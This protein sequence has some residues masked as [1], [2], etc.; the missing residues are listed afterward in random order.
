MKQLKTI[1][2]LALA[3][4]TCAEGAMAAP[5]PKAELKPSD[6]HAANA[7]ENL[8]WVPP[9][10]L[11][12]AVVEQLGRLAPQVKPVPN[13]KSFG[14]ANGE[15]KVVVA[16]GMTPD[17][18]YTYHRLLSNL[19]IDLLVFKG[20]EPPQKVV[21]ELASRLKVSYR[22][23]EA[24]KGLAYIFPDQGPKRDGV[25][26]TINAATTPPRSVVP[27]VPAATAAKGVPAGAAAP[28]PSPTQAA[29]R[30][31]PQQPAPAA[32]ADRRS[33]DNLWEL[34][35]LAKASDP[36]LGRSQ[37]RYQGSAADLD[38]VRAGLFPRV[39]TSFGLNYVDQ[40]Y[41]NVPPPA[42]PTQNLT[43]FGY[44]YS[45]NASVPLLHFPTHYNIA[46][47]K[48]GVRGE[49]A[50]LTAAKQNLI[51]KLVDAYFGLLKAR[52]D[53]QIA[54][55]EIDRVRQ[56]LEQAQA[57]LKA[58]TGD[59]ISVYEA[60]A[61]LDSVIADLSRA[62]SALRLA[63]QKLSSIVGKPVA[64][65]PDYLP[66]QPGNPEPDDIEWWLTTMEERDPLI[67]QAREG[68]AGTELQT[69]AARAEY[70]PTI[71]AVAAYRISKGNQYPAQIE[72]HT[73]QA[74]AAISVP[75]YSG[76]ETKARIQRATANESER[77]YNL[78]QVREQRRENTKLTF[79]N[80]RYNLNIIR[81]LE[82][83]E[84]SAKIQL[85]AVR[86]GRSIGTR[87][88]IDLL[89]AEHDYSVAQR[90]LQNALYDNVVRMVQLKAAA[91]ILGEND[92]VVA[93]G[94]GK[95]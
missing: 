68:L 87:T 56:A 72:T 53:E 43:L 47:A 86:K 32:T 66:R 69:K 14:A 65:V 64:A 74:G 6:T 77:R 37:A 92:V 8:P 62:E 26:L 15:A 2:L 75:L 93:A 28:I 13:D 1:A 80:L 54:R 71:D 52:A 95:S 12:R 83:K 61:R 81:A 76:G 46:S 36:E 18:T 27:P 59:I 45:I 38:V 30:T 20:D 63:E 22:R 5:A 10:T 50:G 4:L 89:N 3:T 17:E 58:G 23:D 85:D 7:K 29:A 57:F 16:C 41:S 90:D 40:S 84:A 44:D 9:C 11:A 49:E 19:G 33:E 67:K 51:V 35:L 24:A 94:K 79:F 55:G 60:Q 25:R 21:Q 91:G 70:L 78:D 42:E 88:A 34:Y 82:Q 39:G 73:W 48:A 31:A